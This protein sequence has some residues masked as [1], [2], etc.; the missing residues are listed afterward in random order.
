M[1]FELLLMSGLDVRHFFNAS[2]L[3]VELGKSSLALSRESERFS[4]FF[5]R[6]INRRVVLLQCSA[7]IRA[8]P[9]HVHAVHEIT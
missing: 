8:R 7:R 4:F 3:V 5:F 1:L 2:K 6:G 9:N